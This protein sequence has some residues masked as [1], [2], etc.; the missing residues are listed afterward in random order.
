MR[1]ARAAD[2]SVFAASPSA[3]CA[4]DDLRLPLR[5]CTICACRVT[6][7]PDVRPCAICATESPA[8]KKSVCV[9]AEPEPSVNGLES[10]ASSLPSPLRAKSPLSSPPSYSSLPSPPRRASYSLISAKRRSSHWRLFE[11]VSLP[12]TRRYRWRSDVM[13]ASAKPP[14]RAAKSP[15]CHESDR[16]GSPVAGWRYAMESSMLSEACDAKRPLPR[17]LLEG[18]TGSETRPSALTSPN[19]P[20]L[21]IALG[22]KS[23]S[24]SSSS[25]SPT[26]SRPSCGKP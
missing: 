12:N 25:S 16:H 17:T 1:F 26:K 4:S 5:P 20:S 19:P 2:A 22:A 11:L 13:E 15:A 23:H 9:P 18:D 14:L 8:P 24:R 3:L 10:P 21:C 6:P 7:L